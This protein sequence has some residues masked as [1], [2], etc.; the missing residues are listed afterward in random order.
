[1]I[2]FKN[3]FKILWA[4]RG[5]IIMYTAMLL[6][7]TAFNTTSGNNENQFKA[8]KPNIAIINN[9]TS[10][11]I[12][13]NF[14]NYVKE[15]AD[16]V[17]M[18]NDE[19]VIDDALFYEQV[20]AVLFIYDGYTNDYLNNNEKQLDIKYGISS[21]ASYAKMVIEKYLKIAS[22]ANDDITD[23]TSIIN[24]ITYSLS[25]T[26]T[27][28]LD[29]TIDTDS[30]SIAS[31]YFN[32]ANYSMLAVCIYIIAT[33]MNTF[34]K[35]NVR[36]RN[37]VS[38]KKLSA[39][40]R[41]LYL[42]NMVFAMSVWLFV[43][44]TSF[45]IVGKIMFTT[46]GLFLI[47]NSFIFTISALGIGFLIGTILKSKNAI[48]GIMNVIALGSSFLCGCFVPVEFMPSSVVNF[49]KILP[50]YWYVQNNNF[51][52]TVEVFDYSSVRTILINMTVV[53]GFAL[54]F[55]IVTNVIIKLK[56]KQS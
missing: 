33:I 36:K 39:I 29:N 10:S 32:F 50:S 26:A 15:N 12:V 18:E 13:D 11:I 4:N 41:E 6:F 55:F 48:N 45:F 30:L 49:S 14:T 21:H 44:I 46:N 22:I 3:Y 47:L 38:S 43:V 56:V 51:I 16:L 19:S 37:I 53:L 1:M 52:K 42:G 40:T 2:V 20:D 5:V 27:V 9:D 8:S 28:E 23:T 25:K 24:T 7:F 17:E 31:F 54:I 34:N 35:D